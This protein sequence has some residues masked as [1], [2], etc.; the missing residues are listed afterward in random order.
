MR[1]CLGCLLLQHQR[2]N[3]SSERER[4]EG[5]NEAWEGEEENRKGREK[6]RRRR[7]R[8]V[9]ADGSNFVP[10]RPRK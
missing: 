2:N 10:A 5:E 4:G 3:H 9:V 8:R 7:G 6:E 1:E